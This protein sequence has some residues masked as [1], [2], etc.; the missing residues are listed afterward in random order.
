MKVIEIKNVEK[1]YNDSEVQVHA[2]NG[3]DLSFE[4]GEFAAIVGPS[5]SGKT[6]FSGK[7]ANMLKSKKGRH[8]LLV[9]GDVYRPAAIEQLKVLGEQI[10]CPV[11]TE[12]GSKEPVKIASNSITYAGSKG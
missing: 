5:G 9:A 3:V 12:E 10:N 4:E 7:L 8:P 6:T 1:V 11:Y 2:V